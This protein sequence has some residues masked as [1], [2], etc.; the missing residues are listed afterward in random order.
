MGKRLLCM[1]LAV[2][3]L[4]CGCGGGPTSDSQATDAGSTSGAGEP[5]DYLQN[6]KELAGEILAYEEEPLVEYDPD[7]QVYISL[8]NQDCDFYPGIS[9]GGRVIILT[10]EHYDV[11][12]IQLNIPS[13]TQYEISIEDITPYC[14]VAAYNSE[15]KSHGLQNYQYIA[16]QGVDWHEIAQKEAEAR[17]AMTLAQ[18]NVSDKEAYQAYKE[19]C[20]AYNELMAGYQSQYENLPQEQIPQFS[21][22]SLTYRFTGLGSHE[23]TVESVEFVIGGETYTR[24]IGQW[25]LHK[26][27]PQELADGNNPVG[28]KQRHMA[29]FV[30][31][32][33]PYSDGYIQLGR[34]FTFDAQEDLTLT[35][36]HQLGVEV[37]I[38]GARVRIGD[39][40]DYFWDMQRPLEVEAGTYVE[41]DLFVKDARLTQYETCLTTYLVM[42][43]QIKNKEYGMVVPWTATY[44]HVQVWDTYLMAFEGIDI[45]KYYTCY[46]ERF[47]V[48][49]WLQELP[50]E[51]LK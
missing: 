42:D 17:A 13:Q 38:L 21:A 41:I 11:S 37:D 25:R 49:N 18:Q 39:A 29:S 15:R 10:R 23:E 12:R 34:I 47:M 26:T 43:Y 33:T 30:I 50:E 3:L 7:R 45:G 36:V 14:T 16:L 51:W 6:V 31:P 5:I 28:L 27:M 44:S 20:D 32:G 2:A 19:I 24:N 35:G 8:E 22:Y 4:L 40:A 1:I 46:Y 48:E 9:S